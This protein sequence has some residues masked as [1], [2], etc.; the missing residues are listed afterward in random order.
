MRLWNKIKLY[1]ENL[2]WST[3]HDWVVT[4]PITTHSGIWQ[5]G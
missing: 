4:I 1:L 5:F 2:M 3:W